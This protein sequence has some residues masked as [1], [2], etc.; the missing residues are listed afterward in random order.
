MSLVA[1]YALIIW[2]CGL[3]VYM[4]SIEMAACAAWTMVAMCLWMLGSVCYHHRCG[5]KK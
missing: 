5:G 1:F 4:D 2:F 3:A